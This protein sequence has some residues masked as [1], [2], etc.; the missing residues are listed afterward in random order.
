MSDLPVL[1]LFVMEGCASC[2]RTRTALAA[3]GR[4]HSLVTVVER[5]LDLGEQRPAGVIGGP[6]LVFGGVVVALGTPDCEELADKIEAMLRM[7]KGEYS[8]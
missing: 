5:R 8:R 2:A 4:L 3:C 6:A 7:R 1:D